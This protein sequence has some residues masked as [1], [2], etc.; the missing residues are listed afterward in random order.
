MKKSK[1]ILTGGLTMI[2]WLFLS[3]GLAQAQEIE[4]K[5][6]LGDYEVFLTNN[7]SKHEVA[8]VA[9]LRTAK[10]G[11]Y[12]TFGLVFVANRGGENKGDGLVCEEAALILDRTAVTCTKLKRN[13][14]GKITGEE[15]LTVALTGSA[16]C[17]A[18]RN[19][20]DEGDKDKI[21]DAENE[22]CNDAPD[23]KCI[24]YDLRQRGSVSVGP[25]DAGSGSGRRGT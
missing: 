7:N 11:A 19:A 6:R 22:S 17:E 5:D 8:R 13:P 15:T 1:H 4:I 10:E 18:L 12:E 21:A 2:T 23:E 16:Y 20:L 25:P 14:N 9:I 3:G 24:C